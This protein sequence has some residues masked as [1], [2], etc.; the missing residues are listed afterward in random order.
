MRAI[1]NGDIIVKLVMNGGIEIGNLPKENGRNIGLERLR[2]NGNEVV[3]LA[4]LNEIY[5]DKD[6]ILHCIDDYENCK[7]LLMQYKDR[8]RLIKDN[9]GWRIKTQTEI[10]TFKNN[11]YQRR[12][13]ADY[14]KEMPIGDQLD[15]IL[16]YFKAQTGLTEEL[17]TILNKVDEIKSRWP[18]IS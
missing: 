18:K 1:V 6:G 5:V 4:T 8:R 3:D 13:K 16:K 15:S 9:D 11:E 2:W 7:K 14:L 10:D 17:Q 12:R